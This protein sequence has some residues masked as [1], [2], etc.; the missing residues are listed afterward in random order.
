MGWSGVAVLVFPCRQAALL[1]LII[2]EI[3]GGEF[4]MIVITRN[5]NQSGLSPS[6]VD[7]TAGQF[8]NNN[9]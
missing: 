5:N 4:K 3:A 7:A 9:L 8:L 1:L 2:I 6:Q